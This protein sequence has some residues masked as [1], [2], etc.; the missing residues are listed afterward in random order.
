MRQRLRPLAGAATAIAGACAGRL[1]TSETELHRVERTAAS[2]ARLT[3]AESRGRRWMSLGTLVQSVS[4]VDSSGQPTL[5]HAQEWTQLIAVYADAWLSDT[6]T[7]DGPCQHALFLGLGGGI[8]VRTLKVLHDRLVIHCIE[9]DSEVVD[10][11]QRYFGLHLDSRCT[12]HVQD[13]AEY[14]KQRAA[15]P[16]QQFDL[17]VVDCVQHK[18]KPT[19]QAPSMNAYENECPQASPTTVS[20]IALQMVSCYS[21]SQLAWRLEAF[22]L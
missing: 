21:I 3:V 8:V 5:R 1:W 22:V 19:T 13:A 11:S 14:V 16:S 15:T 12:A 9:H 4:F 10:A 2:G 6:M 18:S 20:P 7:R 17:I